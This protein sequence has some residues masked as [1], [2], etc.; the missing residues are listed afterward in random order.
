VPSLWFENSPLVVHEAFQ[1]GVP[2]V[3]ARIGG[4]I[5]LVDEGRTG[6]LYEP[7]APAGLATALRPFIEDPSLCRRLAGNVRAG[8]PVKSLVDDAR[9]W[10][11]RYAD[12]I[13]QRS[14]DAAPALT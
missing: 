3:A 1:A 13:R 8:R 2:V 4:L 5:D 14:A 10:E 12:V 7:G 6:F 11:R 9:Q